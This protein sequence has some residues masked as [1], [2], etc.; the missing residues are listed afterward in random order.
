M[1][2]AFWNWSIDLE[3]V[4]IRFLLRQKQKGVKAK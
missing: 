4:G 3:G 2:A 1:Q